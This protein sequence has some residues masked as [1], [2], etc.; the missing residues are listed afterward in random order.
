HKQI[1]ERVIEAMR[2]RLDEPLSLLD[3]A[4]VAMISPFHFDRVFRHTV[5]LTPSQFLSALR[6]QAAKKLLLTTDLSVT[7]VCFEVGYNSLGTFIT[8]FTQLVGV[9]PRRLRRLAEDLDRLNTALCNSCPSPPDLIPA[10]GLIGQVTTVLP[11]EGP[12]MVGLFTTPIPQGLPIGCT[13]LT[14]PGR[15]Q[16]GVV[17]DGQYY[18]FAAA[19]ESAGDAVPILIGESQGLQVGIKGP[20]RVVDGQAASEPEIVLR[21]AQ[22][23]DPPLLVS[24]PLLLHKNIDH[25]T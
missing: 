10:D 7:D 4:E 2:T 21:Y 24:L 17:P 18:G 3:L 14:S 19:L 25:L 23:T 20:L 15:F 6:I 8:R 12:I 16:L 5:G 13:L 11:S 1:I 9:A 22:P